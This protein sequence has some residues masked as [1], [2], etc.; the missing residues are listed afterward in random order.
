M[1]LCAENARV[2]RHQVREFK[3][4]F[5]L[6][7]SVCDVLVSLCDVLVSLCDVLVSL[8]HVMISFLCLCVRKTREQLA[9]RY[10]I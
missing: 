7:V 1:S 9:V 4:F 8:C 6:C 2:A 5:M 3:I 10:E